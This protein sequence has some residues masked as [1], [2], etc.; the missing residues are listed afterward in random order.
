MVVKE[1]SFTWSFGAITNSSASGALVGSTGG[2]SAATQFPFPV[3]AAARENTFYVYLAA[4]SGTSSYQ[5]LTGPAAAGPYTVL[6]SGTLST[7]TGTEV[8]IVQLTGPLK[9]VQPRIKTITS[10]AS[11]IKVDFLG[12]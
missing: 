2:G 4:G 8:D 10:T 5:I 6:S 9:Y 3:D 11:L 12:N 1:A 7:V